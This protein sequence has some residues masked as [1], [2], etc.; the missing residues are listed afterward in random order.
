M[1]DMT[2]NNKK[3]PNPAILV[4]FGLVWHV[5]KSVEYRMKTELI[6]ALK[7]LLFNNL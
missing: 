7:D 1:V 5:V 4:N 6:T 3:K 2:L